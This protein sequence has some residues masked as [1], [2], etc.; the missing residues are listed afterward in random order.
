EGTP[1]TPGPDRL[2]RM[3][4]D[5]GVNILGISPTM[6]RVLMRAADALPKRH[7]LSSLRILGGTGEPWNPE[8]WRWFFENVGGGRLPV[9]NYSGGTEVSGGIVSGNV[10]TPLRPCAFSGPVPVMV[11]D[12]IDESGQSVRGQVGELAIRGPWPGMT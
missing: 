10:L 6:V 8:P 4:A 7:A 3:V 2:W 12:V 5:H 9:I 1:D 11:A